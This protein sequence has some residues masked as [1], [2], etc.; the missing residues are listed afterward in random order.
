[1]GGGGG[2]EDNTG[3]SL[4]LDGVV[5]DVLRGMGV[6]A[7]RATFSG[8]GD[9][10]EIY[11]VGVETDADVAAAW[12]GENPSADA[13]VGALQAVPHPVT[14]RGLDESLLDAIEAAIGDGWECGDGSWGD[15]GI[16]VR[17]GALSGHCRLGDPGGDW[18]EDDEG[19]GD[20]GLEEV[21]IGDAAPDAGGG[22][23]AGSDRDVGVSVSP[24][25]K[26]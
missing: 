26:W 18:D 3:F 24:L 21:E 8:S 5:R 9:N 13:V 19:W 25:P 15:V 22:P 20:Q 2:D 10:G 11:W 4:P 14:G 12:F 16:D 17:S 23:E 1:L 7:L 6:L